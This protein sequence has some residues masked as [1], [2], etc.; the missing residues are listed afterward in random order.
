MHIAFLTPEYP[1]SKI[2]HSAGIGSS[3]KNLV[4]ALIREGNEVT[5]FIY[6]QEKSEIFE[7]NNIQF[8]LIKQKKYIFST[9]FFY[10][11][12]LQNYINKIMISSYIDILEAPDWTGITAFMNFKK[13][14]IIRFHG[15]DAY[16]CHLENRKQKAKN[17][18][19]EKLALNK[20]KAFIAPTKFA[21]DLTRKIFNLRANKIEVINYGIDLNRFTNDNLT[22]FENS[23]I[24]YIGTIIR[25]KGVLELL[26]IFEKV[27]EK[28][29]K[30]KLVLIGSDSPDIQTQNKSTWK[31]IQNSFSEKA[32]NQV[33]YLGK[34]PYEEIQDWLKKANLCVF[35]TFA[36]TLGMV[37]I[38]AMAM[39]KTVI[40]SNKEWVFELFDNEKSGFA[41][42]PKN[43]NAFA[44]KMIDL[45]QNPNLCFEVGKNARVEVENKFDIHKIVQQ[46]IEF[47]KKVVDK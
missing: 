36:E 4:T 30:A 8:H 6:G 14:L 29:P 2:Q 22:Y 3:I 46:N 25:K 17:F 13:P 33:S 5:V 37:T 1:H 47:Y 18:W 43:H 10:R 41:I 15:S 40:S 31:L 34:V 20:A 16:F 32:K 28:L 23:L 38:E 39:Q 27:L 19:F 9:W 24:L 45:I 11:K 35:P 12:F 7:E 26:Q 42:D 21:G 44:N